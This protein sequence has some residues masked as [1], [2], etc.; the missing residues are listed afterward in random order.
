M[1]RV[2]ERALGRLVAHRAQD[3]DGL[4]VG[5]RL[6]VAREGADDQRVGDEVHEAEA[7]HD[8]AEHREA[9]RDRDREIAPLARVPEDFVRH[10]LGDQRVHVAPRELRQRLGEVEHGLVGGVGGDLARLDERERVTRGVVAR[11]LRGAVE[12]GRERDGVGLA[13]QRVVGAARMR[14]QPRAAAEQRDEDEDGEATTHSGHRR[15]GRA[16]NRSKK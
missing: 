6:L 15:E 2:G 5:G 11:R 4:E 12:R 1:E 3:L 14:G 8:E 9:G 16:R 7:R 10:L 13:G